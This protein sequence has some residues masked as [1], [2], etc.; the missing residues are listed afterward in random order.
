[1]KVALSTEKEV[2]RKICLTRCIAG[3][4]CGMLFI[5]YH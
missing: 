2:V 5:S 3:L 4:L 1:M